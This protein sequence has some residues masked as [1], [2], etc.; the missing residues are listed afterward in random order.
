EAK[1]HRDAVQQK[2]DGK[3]QSVAAPLLSPDAFVGE[4]RARGD[5]FSNVVDLRAEDYLDQAIRVWLPQAFHDGAEDHSSTLGALRTLAEILSNRHGDQ[6]LLEFVRTPRSKEQATAVEKLSAAAKANTSGDYLSA[7]DLSLQ[8]EQRFARN[9]N[10]AGAL[11]ARFETVYALQRS[12]QENRHCVTQAD[13]AITRLQGHR[14]PWLET[15]LYLERFL[16]VGQLARLNE[17]REDLDKAFAVAEKSSYGTLYLR[18]IGMAAS[19]HRG[20][21]DAIFFDHQGL[22]RYWEGSYPPARAFQF[23]S[24]IAFAAEDARRWSLALAAAREAVRAIS[25]GDQA[26]TE[27]LARYQLA[28]YALM[29][30]DRALADSES[31]QASILLARLPQNDVTRGYEVNQEVRLARLETEHGRVDQAW[32]HLKRAQDRLPKTRNYFTTLRFYNAL[33][34]LQLREGNRKEAEQSL[35]LA[36]EMSEL[37]LTSLPDE[38]DKSDW[39]RETSEAYRKLAFLRWQSHDSEGAWKIWEWYLGAPVRGMSPLRAINMNSLSLNFEAAS[40]LPSMEEVSR[41]SSALVDETVVSYLLLPEGI[42]I[43]VFDDR[44]LTA[45]WVVAAPR[46]LERLARRFREECAHPDSGQAMLRQD[47]QA[48]YDL[49]IAPIADRLSPQRILVIEPDG[50]LA[51][52][53]ITA[54]VDHAGHY[55]SETFDIVF[56]PGLLYTQHL[57]RAQ[58]FS[59]HL[60]AL[61]VGPPPLAGDL[62]AN[63]APLQDAAQEATN[64]ASRFDAGIL[65]TG[66]QATVEKVER[67][68]GQAA[69]FHFAG[70]ALEVGGKPA[71]LLAGVRP[72]FESAVFNA[73]RIQAEDLRHLQLAV[74]S[75]CSTGRNERSSVSNTE[76]LAR[77]FLRHGVPDVVATRWNVDSAATAEFMGYFYGALLKGQSV[78]SSLKTAR[79]E[80]RHTPSAGHPFYWAAFDAFG[81]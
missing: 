36:V 41:A 49:L 28:R 11:R 42:A 68:L 25:L 69:I 72:S 19:L 59:R 24:D 6:W 50:I 35:V 43:W 81:R 9:R 61:V 52:V 63:L 78:S 80:L 74:L 57:R 55:L 75:A 15:Q 23:Y 12:N 40:A 71:L 73:E 46:E 47:A 77:S 29:I 62:A 17:A 22:V 48:L 13:S 7:A 58:S 34:D 33:S 3:E 65:L 51:E 54:L 66:S 76:T 30:G 38:R 16:C 64:I 4:S 31:G 67:A 5:G 39:A 44:G 60:R 37:G 20:E 1:R 18:A 14:Y 27:G 32:M 26:L 53:P 56:S 79:A 45:K 2:L 70:H 8:A 10:I 21:G